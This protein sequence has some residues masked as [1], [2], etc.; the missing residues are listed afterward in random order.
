MFTEFEF[1]QWNTH[2]LGLTPA[3]LRDLKPLVVLA[4]P[5]GAGKSRYL[6]L[7]NDIV[8]QAYSEWQDMVR[9]R[10]NVKALK[11]RP[12]SGPELESYQ[13]HLLEL[14]RDRLRV[15]RSPGWNDYP[16]VIALTYSADSVPDPQEEPPSRARELVAS[17]K[18]GGFGSA[19]TSLHAYFYQ[20][21]RALHDADNP[22]TTNNP[23]FQQGFEDAIAFNRILQ[24][25]L[26][27][28]IEPDVDKHGG[29]VPHFRKRLFQPD[30]LSEGE[31]ILAVW[32]ILLHRQREWLQ[33]ACVLIDEP[34]NHLH[35]DVCIRAL[36]ALRNDILGPGGQIWLATHSIPLIAYAGMESVYFVDHGSIEYAG[37]KIEKVIDRLLGGEQGRA[38]LHTFISDAE[39]M[40]FDVFAAQCLLPPDVASAR[41]K[42]PQQEQM[43]G[44]ASKIGAHKENV[45]ILDFAA[46]RG[47]LAAALKQA[48][49][50]TNRKFTYYAFNDA[51]FSKKE[52]LQECTQHIRQLELPLPPENYLVDSLYKLTGPGSE[53]MDLVVMC[54]V[55][56][57][58]PVDDWQR[59]FADIV[60]VL[61]EDGKLV[62][63]EDQLPNVG[64]LPHENGYVILDEFA[65]KELFNSRSAV[66]A[67]HSEQDARLTAFAIT[68][69][70]LKQVTSETI[71]KA[72]GK[73]M[74]RAREEIRRIRAVSMNERTYQLGRRHAHFTMLYANAQLALEKY[75]ESGRG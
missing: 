75:P 32:A 51:R 65:L 67:L 36:F 3:R 68:R 30:E 63:L 46:G 56:H 61:A 13:R 24:A 12:Q 17:N 40:A 8:R 29:V 9:L 66:M 35:P 31:A 21:A 43:V 15:E 11:S 14:E 28:E 27:A 73:V 64:E 47:R 34:E 45:R 70:A 18:T 25:L 50:A 52:E 62:I 49:L 44:I 71:G 69:S 54:N 57:E 19:R 42:D 2:R 26:S 39:E 37:N 33:D 74:R 41:E 10:G 53:P 5:N 20:V 7:V 4:G 58:I 48:G 22:R 16:K 1:P 55:L 60:E 72:L 38:R 59:C 23:N 6:R